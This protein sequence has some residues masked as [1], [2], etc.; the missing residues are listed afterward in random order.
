MELKLINCELCESRLYRTTASLSSL[1]GRDIAN[2]TYL[3]TLA[4]YLML[5]DDKQHEAAK[6]YAKLTAQY[7]SYNNFKTVATDLYML[8]YVLNNIDNT[9]VILKNHVLSTKF[10]RTLQFDAHR[11][12]IFTRIMARA[13]DRKN[14][15]NS[16]FLRLE[17]QL[18]I[19]ESNYKQY[20]RDIATW[21]DLGY[22][23][24][25]R[26]LR[27][28]VQDIR[29]IAMIGELLVPLG[30]MLKYDKLRVNVDYSSPRTVKIT[31][32]AGVPEENKDHTDGTYSSAIVSDESRTEIIEWCKNNNIECNT[33]DKIHCTIIHSETPVQ[34]LMRH[35]GRAV[36]LKASIEGWDIFG[37]K[38]DCLVLKIKST[39]LD[40]WN[41]L[42]MG[43]GAVSDYDDY[44][45]HI[46][47]NSEYHGE[48]P[49]SVPDFK[50]S[51]DVLEVTPL[52]ADYYDKDEVDEATDHHPSAN[53]VMEDNIE[54]LELFGSGRN[55]MWRKKSATSATAVFKVG[56]VPYKF[57]AFK[58]DDMDDMDDVDADGV[59]EIEFEIVDKALN[60]PN[61]HGVSGTGNAAQVMG[62]VVDIIR[63]FLK[64]YKV[65]QLDFVGIGA[66][67]QSLYVRMIQRLLPDWTLVMKNAVFRLIAPTDDEIDEA[68][69]TTLDYQGNCTQDDVIEYIFGDVNEFARLVDEHG[70]EFTVGDLVVKYDSKEDIH[71]FYYKTPG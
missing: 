31:E 4:I 37:D 65:S 19:N 42:M 41:K 47:I 9:E 68:T 18:D 62:T 14:V 63:E 2:L 13:S 22:S 11:H 69:D 29:K 51:F 36:N 35:D 38:Q 32:S 28:I 3:N 59:W 1:N 55:W 52:E 45:A 57:D 23:S 48:M 67:R 12:L 70:D 20:R 66:S 16:F 53:I 27:M 24:K 26:V 40:K 7:G 46:T 10:L 39:G 49:T 61:V 64:I 71:H 21:G 56:G 34:D 17:S 15:A 6:E 58:L 43:A 25:Q 60:L 50:I 54:L 8:C 30:N 44:L 33:E 5:Q